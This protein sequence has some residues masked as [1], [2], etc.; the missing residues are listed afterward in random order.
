MVVVFKQE[1][2]TE[3]FLGEVWC[4]LGRKDG[5]ARPLYLLAY[6]GRNLALGLGWVPPTSNKIDYPN[7]PSFFPL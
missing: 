7:R 1:E 5:L 6:F 4:V 2:A 3:L